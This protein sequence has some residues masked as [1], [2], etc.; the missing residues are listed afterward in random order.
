MLAR[1]GMCSAGELGRPFNISQ[2][3]ASKHL[4]VLERAGLVRRQIQGREHRFQL[5]AAALQ[6]AQDWIG[7]HSAFWEG[8]LSRLEQVVEADEEEAGEQID[9]RDRGRHS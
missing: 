8:T 3:T 4:L 6:E 5:E 7:R 2:P 9:T 1:M